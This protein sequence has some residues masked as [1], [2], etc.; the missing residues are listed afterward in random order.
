MGRIWANYA[1]KYTQGVIKGPSSVAFCTVIFAFVAGSK[2]EHIWDNTANP[3]A[4]LIALLALFVACWTAYF[5]VRAI[6]QLRDGNL[7]P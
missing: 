3:R 6:R 4:Y 1:L 5:L 2:S 7:I